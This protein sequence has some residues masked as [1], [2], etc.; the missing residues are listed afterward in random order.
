MS[1]EQIPAESIGFAE[2]MAEL[3]AIVRQIDSDR[4]D[5]D[6]AGAGAQST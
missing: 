4:V 5:V 1:D 3:D 6:L 2:A